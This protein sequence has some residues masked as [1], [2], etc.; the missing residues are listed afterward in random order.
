MV[1][2]IGQSKTHLKIHT[3]NIP[4]TT[5]WKSVYSVQVRAIHS[6]FSITGYGCLVS[7]EHTEAMQRDGDHSEAPCISRLPLQQKIFLYLFLAI[8]QI[9]ATR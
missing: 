3:F 7:G 1:Y 4:Q 5:G 8:L 9:L 6:Y 2:R